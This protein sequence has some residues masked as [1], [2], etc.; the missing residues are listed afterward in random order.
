MTSTRPMGAWCAIAL[1]ALLAARGDA[2]IGQSFTSTQSTATTL[3]TTTNGVTRGP[4]TTMDSVTLTTT[5]VGVE[6][7]TVPAGTFTTCN[8]G[9]LWFLAGRGIPVKLQTASGTLSAT[10]IE[11]DGAPL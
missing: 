7:I 2:A 4:T 10:S 11:V 8:F 5:F 3:T 1:G 9:G 6:T